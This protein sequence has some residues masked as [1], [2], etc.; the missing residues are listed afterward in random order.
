MNELDLSIEG[1]ELTI[2]DAAEKLQ[3]FLAKLLLW[4]WDTKF[5]VNFFKKEIC[6]HLET[7]QNSFK[8]YF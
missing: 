5:S 4:R 2:M 1:L 6:S 8:S 7:L 3:T